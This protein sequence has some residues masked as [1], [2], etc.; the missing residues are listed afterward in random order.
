M[1]QLDAAVAH[2]TSFLVT[3]NDCQYVRGQLANKQ[4]HI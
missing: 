3:Y 4:H 1:K 2:D